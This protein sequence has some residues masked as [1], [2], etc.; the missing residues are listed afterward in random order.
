MEPPGPSLGDGPSLPMER[1]SLGGHRDATPSVEG[2]R[3]GSSLVMGLVSPPSR[4]RCPAS[5]AMGAPV[6]PPVEGAHG[7][8]K[9][10]ALHAPLLGLRRDTRLTRSGAP[11]GVPPE[12]T[13]A[14]V[15]TQLVG[16]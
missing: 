5:W 7:E 15:A 4:G 13:D 6:G 12:T 11:S 1:P 8:T 14:W 10:P 16:A 2:A 3:V 9:E